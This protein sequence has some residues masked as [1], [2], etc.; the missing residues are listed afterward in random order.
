MTFT[1][2]A[3]ALER[4]EFPVPVESQYAVEVLV[5]PSPPAN[6]RF[7]RR[8]RR[9]K[10]TDFHLDV[11]TNLA[12]GL[13]RVSNAKIMDPPAS[14]ALSC[15]LSSLSGVAPPRRRSSRS[16]ALIARRAFLRGVNR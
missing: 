9:V 15:A 7:R 16:R 14:T 5:T 4:S 10:S 8:F 11:V 12:K 1:Y 13:A 2:P 6:A 3:D